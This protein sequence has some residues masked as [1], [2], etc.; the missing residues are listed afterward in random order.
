M[1]LVIGGHPRSGTTLLRRLLDHHPE[2]ALTGEFANFKRLGR[3][4]NDHARDIARRW[5][6]IRVK[7]RSILPQ[8]LRRKPFPTV[9]KHAF[10][11]RYL[12]GILTDGAAR[13]DSP[14]IERTL[15]RIF[16][17]KRIVGDKYPGYVFRLAELQDPALKRLV[18]YRDGRDVVSSALKNARTKWAHRPFSRKYDSAEKVARRWVEAIGEMETHADSIHV[19]RYEDLVGD[20]AAA[21]T[22]VGEWLDVDPTLFPV[23]MVRTTSVG[24][25]GKGLTDEE[26]D[27]VTEIAGPTLERYGY[28]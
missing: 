2:I 4:R 10:I 7:E 8:P 6:Q 13:I 9:R 5:W 28:L 11:M 23:G 27:T 16:P 22:A 3:T 15:Q 21:L 1:V 14:A 20:P 25:H 12:T 17:G 24:K 19:L 18:I 26:L